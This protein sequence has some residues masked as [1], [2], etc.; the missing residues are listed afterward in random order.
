M[1]QQ[2]RRKTSSRKKQDNDNSKIEKVELK[3]GKLF[4]SS[5]IFVLV[6]L[7]HTL[8]STKTPVM[9]SNKT[10]TRKQTSRKKKGK[11]ETVTEEKSLTSVA[12]DN[13]DSLDTQLK[14]ELA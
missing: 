8:K 2:P 10:P 12:D 9:P 4:I 3:P 14:K 11:G 1:Q 6:N 5:S 7:E 13:C